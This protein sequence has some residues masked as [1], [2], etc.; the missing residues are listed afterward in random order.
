MKNKIIFFII[1]ILI[2]FYNLALNIS[3]IDKNTSTGLDKYN[4]LLMNN[5]VISAVFVGDIMLS[6]YVA[7][8]VESNF[9]GDYDKLFEPIKPFLENRDIV[10]GNLEGTV[11]DQNFRVRGNVVPILQNPRSGLLSLANV[12]CRFYTEYEAVESL[13]N[14]GFNVLSIANNHIGDAG[15]SGIEDT[16]YNLESLQLEYVGGG[17]NA[18]EA[19]KPYTYSKNDINVCLVGYSNI[20]SSETWE[21]TETRAGISIYDDEEFARDIELIKDKC[22]IIIVSLH[23]GE[24]DDSAPD[25][26]EIETAHYIINKGADIIIGHHPHVIQP[27]EIYNGGLITY[28]LGNFIFDNDNP[29]NSK[30]LLLEIFIDKDKNAFVVQNKI[31]I[32]YKHQPVLQ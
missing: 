25:P 11:T 1:I 17:M 24:E 22:D 9:N 14:A 10:F 8:S 6:R 27:V 19:H 7:G 15:L 12:C 21:A 13:K 29:D 28:S 3:F 20:L 31:L 23:F 26:E 32:N 4:S 5:N 18:L 2:P 30:G 16:I